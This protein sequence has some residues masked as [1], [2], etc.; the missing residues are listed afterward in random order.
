MT[1]RMTT[2]ILGTGTFIALSG[3]VLST[4]ALADNTTQIINGLS[5]QNVYT[6]F[7]AQNIPQNLSQTYAGSEIA[8]VFL[9]ESGV[10]TSQ[11]ASQVLQGVN[12]TGSN[13]DT[14]IVS[15]NGGSFGVASINGNSVQIAEHL[16][17]NGAESLITDAS[18]IQEMSQTGT[19]ITG[20]EANPV[21]GSYDSGMNVGAGIGIGLGVVVLLTAGVLLFRKFFSNKEKNDKPVKEIKPEEYFNNISQKLGGEIIRLRNLISLHENN[22]LKHSADALRN[23]DRRLGDLFSRLS[24]K[25]TTDQVNMA[26]VKYQDLLKKIIYIMDEDHYMDVSL[27]PELWNNA[28]VRKQDSLECVNAVDAQILDNIRQLNDSQ[29]LEFNI[30]MQ[31]LLSNSDDMDEIEELLFKDDSSGYGN[32]RK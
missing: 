26:A 25:G 6:S 29:D 7:D 12:E 19:T 4:P 27:H 13:Y 30:T 28:E 9:N 22:D 31:A 2:A 15:V 17:T 20:T 23:V 8:V 18:L 32:F 10:N 24:R 16:N 1:Q 11:I 21:S 14:V 3:F 5:N